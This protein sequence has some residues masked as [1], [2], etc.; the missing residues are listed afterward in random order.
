VKFLFL[1]N[2]FPGQFRFLIQY[3]SA[4]GHDVLFLSL[5]HSG[6]IIPNVKHLIVKPKGS[7][8]ADSTSMPE[9]LKGWSKKYDISQFFLSA[10]RKLAEEGYSPDFCISHA[11]WGLGLFIKSIFPNTILASYAEWWFRWSADDHY[12]DTNSTYFPPPSDSSRE[13]EQYV[14]MCQ[15]AELSH[16]DFIWSPTRY[17]RDQY[18]PAISNQIE[19]IHEGVII[20]D[21]YIPSDHYFSFSSPQH[22]LTYATRGME[23]M[24]AFE[25][26]VT[27][28]ANLLSKNIFQSCIVGGKDKAFYRKLPPNTRSMGSYARDVFAQHKID[29]Q[30]II[31]KGLLGYTEY[32]QLLLNSGLHVYFT[33]P[34]VP[35]WSLVDAMSSGC[36]V[37]ASDLP[38]VREIVST[39]SD[40][41]VLLVDHINHSESINSII[42]LLSDKPRQK[43]L[44]ESSRQLALDRFDASKQIVKLLS[45]LGL[46]GL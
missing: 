13:R 42:E 3:L 25:H 36:L 44:R 4:K 46:Q 39:G 38:C 22:P 16:S 41:S 24:R 14:N 12:F 15:A 21:E 30:R 17:Q 6:S 23:P 28:A 19:V 33:R 27:I 7:L 11:G 10:F 40:S 45:F 29:A 1:H 35:S 20:S 8:L 34:F 43:I 32:K 5:D 37:V 26:F 31:W 9:T 2:N 18:P